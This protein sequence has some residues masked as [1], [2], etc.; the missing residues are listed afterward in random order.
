MISLAEIFDEAD[1]DAALARFERATA[2]STATRKRGNPSV[3]PLPRKTVGS[4]LGRD[5][6]DAS[7]RLSDR[8][9]S[10]RGERWGP[11]SRRRDRE[12]P[13]ERRRRRRGYNGDSHRDP[14]RAPPPQPIPVLRP[15]SRARDVCR[16]DTGRRRNQCGRPGC[17]CRRIRPRR[18]RRRLRRA[19]CPLPRRRSS[20]P[21]AY[22]VRRSR[23]RT[24]RSTDT[25][26]RR[27]RRTGSTSITDG[28]W[29]SFPVICRR[30][31]TPLWELAPDF[32][33]YVEAVHRLSNLG[34]VVT[35]CAQGS[36]QRRLRRRVEGS[37]RSDIRRRPD[38]PR[39]VLRRVRTSPP[40]SPASTSSTEVRTPLAGP[41]RRAGRHALG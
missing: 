12:R 19:R 39:R 40:R 2:A 5:G 29:P 11:W 38:Q 31:C 33:V 32:N 18:H 10:S 23:R 3:D 4:R 14:R 27:R 21:R 22:V 9:S 24:P 7:R 28:P 6:G 36:S 20:R 26:C 8:R 35:H 16:R 15:R 13:S 34:G 30:T 1:L 25:N 41:F 37:R 17:G